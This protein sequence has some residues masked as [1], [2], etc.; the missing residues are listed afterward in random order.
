MITLRYAHLAD[1]ASEGAR[2]KMIVV[3]I[4]VRVFTT[5]PNEAF[6]LPL[7]YLAM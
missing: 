6:Q 1:Y 7:C 5:S 2:G 4:F 3:G